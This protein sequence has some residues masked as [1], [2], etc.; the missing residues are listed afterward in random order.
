MRPLG[1]ALPSRSRLLALPRRLTISFA[2]CA[3]RRARCRKTVSHEIM[4]DWIQFVRAPFRSCVEVTGI[5]SV[6]EGHSRSPG[7]WEP[8]LLEV[9]RDV[10]SGD[11]FFVLLG[12]SQLRQVVAY[13]GH[14]FIAA[15]RVLLLTERPNIDLAVPWL[16]GGCHA[17]DAMW[18][19][20]PRPAR[21]RQHCGR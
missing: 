12:G 2:R 8:C 20:R 9:L 16:S 6:R 21:F 14:S 4:T 7:K 13:D 15:A 1:N 18:G 10:T 19:S 17:L 5:L 3:F 11:L